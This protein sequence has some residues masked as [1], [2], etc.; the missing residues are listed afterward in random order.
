MLNVYLAATPWRQS[1]LMRMLEKRLAAL[2][3]TIANADDSPSG[4][5]NDVY[6]A[7]HSDM[8]I[9]I[10]PGDCKTWSCAS[11][12]WAKSVPVWGVD[13][14]ARRPPLL[15]QVVRKWFGDADEL[16]RELETTLRQRAA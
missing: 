11:A 6:A 15:E 13:N 8:V 7:A 16:L 10:A 14:A 12:A 3:C 5:V 4:Y 2:G 1:V 9:Y